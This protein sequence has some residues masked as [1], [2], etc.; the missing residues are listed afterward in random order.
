M[1][2]IQNVRIHQK[3]EKMEGVK[4]AEFELK[5]GEDLHIK[6]MEITQGA[7]DMKNVTGLS[8]GASGQQSARLQGVRIKQPGAEV[9]IS[10]DPNVRIEINKQ[11]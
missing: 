11:E 7:K 6:D 5:D 1:K 9:V 10:D 3:S 8:F 2:K 4:G